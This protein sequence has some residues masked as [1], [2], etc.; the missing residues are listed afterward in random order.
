LHFSSTSPSSTILPEEL[1]P[2]PRVG[3]RNA[4]THRRGRERGR[5]RILTSTPEKDRLEQIQLER[6][7]ATG[8]KCNGRNSER[9]SCRGVG[10]QRRNIKRKIILPSSD[11][12]TSE[13]N[14]SDQMCD[15]DH[16]QSLGINDFVVVKFCGKRKITHFVGQ[17]ME[18]ESRD[19]YRVSF[20]R[21]V[22]NRLVFHFPQNEDT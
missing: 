4:A 15:N 8:N 17:I 21:N 1:E 18:L 7:K 12:E 19:E 5:T 3:P 2:L 22:Q 16:N 20:L 14:D 13:C 11:S 9:V 6:Q 10:R